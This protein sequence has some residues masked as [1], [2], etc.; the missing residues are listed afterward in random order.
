[1]RNTTRPFGER[2]GRG[3]IIVVGALGAL[4]AFDALLL[5]FFLL[6]A[7]IFIAPPGPYI[8][9]VMFLGVPLTIVVGGALAWA[10]YTAYMDREEPTQPG[11]PQTGKDQTANGEHVHV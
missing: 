3:L 5:F 11:D 1:M 6:F 9:L 2:V 7:A 4:A 10:G 8:G